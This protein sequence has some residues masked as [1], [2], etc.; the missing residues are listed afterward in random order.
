MAVGSLANTILLSGEKERAP[1]NPTSFALTSVNNCAA[2][3]FIAKD[4]RDVKSVYLRF[5]TVTAAGSVEV[6]IETI[7]TS[8]GKPTG[9]LYDANATKTITPVAN[10]WV[11]ATFATLPTTGLTA[12][13]E[14]AV[15]AICTVAGTSHQLTAYMSA[16]LSPAIL[17]TAAD[18]STRSNLSV[19]AYNGIFSLVMEDDDEWAPSIAY[20]SIT[21]RSAYGTNAVGA[22]FVVP[23]GCS[24]NVVAVGTWQMIKSGTP[25][26]D[27]R[28]RIWDGNNSV[29]SGSDVTV[30]KNDIAA[31]NTLRAQYPTAVSLGAGTY[32]LMLES[33][34]SANSSNCWA[35]RSLA[36]R[37]SGLIP[38]GA[39]YTGTSDITASPP[40]WTD[41]ATEAT[42]LFVEIDG[43][44]SSGGSGGLLRHPGMMGGF[45]G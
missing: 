5:G 37:A 28:F 18:G 4:T 8:S 6:R 1:G 17:L 45:K 12:G 39:I 20:Y 24:W 33:A 19:T 27:A 14:Y 35:I 30:G 23:T 26:G 11:Q 40:T 21:G 31:T 29:V 43:M 2:L 34:S 38:S 42:P 3:R 9:T 41:T 15:V 22:K 36:A 13:T 7:D 10:S 44:S 25:A 32:R 16:N